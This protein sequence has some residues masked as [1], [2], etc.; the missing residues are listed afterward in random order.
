MK[1]KKYF[2]IL[3]LFFFIIIVHSYLPT[4]KETLSNSGSADFNWQPTKCVFQGINH[5][6]SYLVRDGKCSIFMSQLGEYAQGMYILLYPY[7]LLDWDTAKVSWLVT[8]ILL[9]FL[10][11]YFLSKKNELDT[12]ETLFVL[13]VT[14]YTIVTRVNFIMGQHTI[15]IL[16]FL[17]LPFIWKNKITYIL[18]GVSYFKY[19]IGYGLFLFYLI[20]KKYKILFLTLIPC[21]IG[22]ATYSFIT[23]TGLIENIF[24]PFNLA[25]QN[26]GAG[27]VV[28]NLF[29]FSFLKNI[30]FLWNFNYLIMLIL[31][32]LFNIFF[33]V[34]I[35][36]TSDDLLQLSMLCLLILIS[37]PHWGHDNILLIPFLIY[38]VK[39]YNKKKGLFRFNLFF[40]IYFLHLYKGIQIYTAKFLK[41]I[42]LNNYFIELSYL[43]FS[44]MNLIILIFLIV[45]NLNFHYKIKEYNDW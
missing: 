32:L 27:N 40:S 34:K 5:Y 18:S 24:Q 22:W 3:F 42:S 11:V 2:E 36:K 13:F 12:I 44:Y 20:T 26:A 33:I 19:H 14:F 43:L 15:L 39:N 4:I 28:N 41:L 16:T 10:V 37:T 30:S 1:N 38:S 7:S 9:L 45:I 17:S 8:N 23:D 21:I 35:K 29:L 31:T 25:L 6:S